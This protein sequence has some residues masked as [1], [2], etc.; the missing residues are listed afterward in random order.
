MLGIVVQVG[1]K[2]T[3]SFDGDQRSEIKLTSCELL[4]PSS[5]G[6]VGHDRPDR[7]ARKQKQGQKQKPETWLDRRDEHG[8]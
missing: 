1:F 7:S 3:M 5:V 2:P 4:I 6:S 8:E